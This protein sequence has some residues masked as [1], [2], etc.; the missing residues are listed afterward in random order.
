MSEQ[1]AIQAMLE[2]GFAELREGQFEEA[3]TIFT[4]VH[5]IEGNN[6]AALRGR[7]LALIQL[8]EAAH[9]K[10]NFLRAKDLNP[11]EAE[12][13]MGW[14]L[15]QAMQNKIYE[16]IAAYENLLTQKPN[17]IAAYIQ[18]GRLQLK[19]GAISKGRDILTLAL[20]HRPHLEQR[21][22]I[23]A[24]LREQDKLDKGRYYRPDFERLKNQDTIQAFFQGIFSFF[25]KKDKSPI[26]LKGT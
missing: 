16:A 19:I 8:G 2:Q 6:D 13:W 11:D 22:V 14:G 18:L 5:A 12:N 4:N 9:T 21:R 10:S 15:S 26:P 1:K 20:K 3:V 7:G 17:H 24:I 25:K 23:E